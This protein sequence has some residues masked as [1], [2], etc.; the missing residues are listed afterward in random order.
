MFWKSS[1]TN[2]F[3]VMANTGFGDLT[4]RRGEYTFVVPQSRLTN[5][6]FI[7]LRVRRHIFAGVPTSIE[8][9]GSYGISI[10]K[11]PRYEV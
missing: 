1:R 11:A 6:G 7:P 8:K 5:K 4:I 3:S 2:M 9:L 10:T